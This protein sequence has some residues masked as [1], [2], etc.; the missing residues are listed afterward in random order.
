[1]PLCNFRWLIALTVLS[2]LCYLSAPRARYSRALADNFDRVTDRYYRPI[3]DAGLFEDAMNGLVS[4]KRLDKNSR[5]IPADN[6]P[7]FENDLNQEFD[8]IGILQ[9]LDPKTKQ[10]LVLSPLPDGPAVAAGV[11]AGDRILKIDGQSTHG[12]SLDDSSARIKG[13][14]G[15]SVTIA[16]LH[17]GA[18]EPAE[19]T[20]VRRMVHEDTVEGASRGPDGRWSFRLGTRFAPRDG[21]ASDARPPIGYIW[22]KSFVE[23]DG[24]EK[25][26]AADLRAALEQLRRENAR[27]LVLDLRDD[28]GGALKAAVDV[29]DMFVRGGQIVTMRGRGR[30][31]L[32]AYRASGKAAFADIPIAVLVNDGSA[33][34][35]EIVAACLQ[36]NG[37]AIVAGQRSYGKGTVQEVFDL[38]PA[39]G[40]MK[41]TIATYWRPSGQDIN[42]PK[43]D[44]KDV[45]WGVSPNEGYDV[46]VTDEER[47]RLLQWQHDRELAALTG[48]KPPAEVSDC[49]LRKALEYL[50]AKAK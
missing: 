47:Q 6:K 23:A 1:M 29:C 36:D 13:R 4:E 32:R 19:L 12:M 50:E 2:S 9:V 28:R 20:I 37:R 43:D 21:A 41:L 10:L 38:G 17:S 30:Q 22:I 40:A 3:S 31:V 45:P 16:V 25:S 42:R 39:L 8:G 46:P 34:A 18:A 26:T 24:G 49:V 7:E 11:R 27:G 48:A 35:S 5:Y 33:S 15:T 14:T 44:G